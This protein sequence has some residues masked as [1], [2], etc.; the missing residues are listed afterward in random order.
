MPEGAIAEDQEEA[1]GGK[2]YSEEEVAEIK[3]ALAAANKEAMERRKALEAVPKDFDPE[4]WTKLTDMEKRQEEEAAMAR[5]EFEALREKDREEFKAKL[6]AKEEHA[7]KIASQLDQVIRGNEILRATA[8]HDGYAHLLPTH[9]E[10]FVQVVEENGA[11]KAVV[12]NDDGGRRVNDNGEPM[13]ISELVGW[14]R[15]QEQF[16]PLFK[17]QGVA[18]GGATGRGGAGGALKSRK[19]MSDGEKA[20]YISEKGLDA[21]KRDILGIR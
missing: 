8:E 20:Q 5:G 11:R 3:R 12:V 9:V 7:Q 6:T 21:F 15:A 1:Q 10:R 16:W 13:S 2:V 19:D 4:K 17:G 14:M 18:G